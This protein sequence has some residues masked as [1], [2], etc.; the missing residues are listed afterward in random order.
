MSDMLSTREAYGKAVVE[1]GK[2][3]PK[4]VV[5]EADIST[6]TK[7]DLFAKAFPDRY[8]NIGVAEQNEMGIAA[9]MATCGLIPFVRHYC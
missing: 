2:A 6:S 9:G 5:L 8:F 1:L 3:N 7:T 4:V